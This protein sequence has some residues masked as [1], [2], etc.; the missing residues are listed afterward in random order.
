MFKKIRNKI[1]GERCSNNLFWK[2]M[3]KLK[4][5]VFFDLYRSFFVYHSVF[6]YCKRLV[7]SIIEKKLWRN[8]PADKIRV[9]VIASHLPSKV[10][11]EYFGRFCQ[12]GFN[13]NNLILVDSIFADYYAIVDH[14]DNNQFEYYNPRKTIVFQREPS[15]VRKDWPTWNNLVEKNFFY[16][17]NIKRHHNVVEW[18]LS[19]N[20]DWLTNNE[21]KKTKLLSTVTSDVYCFPGHRKR[22]DFIQFLDSK[23]DFDVYGWTK[24][25]QWS[26][27]EKLTHLKHY[28]GPLPPVNKD[29]GLFPYHYTFVSE[30]SQEEN[31]FTEKI[32]DA[33]LAECLCFYWGCPNLEEFIDSR[34]FIRLDLDDFPAAME[35]INQAIKNDEWGK[36]IGIIREEKKKI[37]NELQIMPTIEKIINSCSK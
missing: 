11:K 21:I 18:H 36:R 12:T 30:N 20:Y 6:Y 3:I 33:I 25:H 9:K 17:Y 1:E 26:R 24:N 28:R 8:V 35:T 32:I 19:K 37:L 23:I 29:D 4:D 22:L 16:F 31:Y 34:V 2:V 15:L 13:W 10:S 5:I 27:P 7:L 14:P